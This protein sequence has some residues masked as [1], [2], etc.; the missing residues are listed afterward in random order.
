MS[1]IVAVSREGAAGTLTINRPDAMNALNAA[2]LAGLAR[3]LDEF[4]ADT[5]IRCIVITGQ[6]EKSFVSGADITEF[7]DAGP[8]EALAIARRFKAVNDRIVDC[9]KPVI[10]SINGF[11]LGGGLELALACD[12]RIAASE[13]RFGLP[14][15][16]LGIIPGG[17]AAARLTRLVG[18]SAARAL[19][20]TGEMIGAERALTLGILASVHPAAELAA[21]TRKLAE[22]IGAYSPFALAQL[23]SAL[24]I[25]LDADVESACAAE[26]KAFALCYSTQDQKEGARAFL[27]KRPARFTGR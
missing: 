12:I 21:A 14:E 15:I 7:L 9:P 2:V 18:S 11:C 8:A 3:G 25:A 4:T 26:I 5:A 17:G 13:A 27:E 16:R 6:G 20:M 10:A 23:K 19:A 24:N 1:E 22:R